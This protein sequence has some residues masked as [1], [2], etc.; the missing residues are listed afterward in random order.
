IFK[1]I[2]ILINKTFIDCK[3][4]DVVGRCIGATVIQTREV[5]NKAIGGV[6]FLDEAYTLAP[7][8]KESNDCARE[9]ADELLVWMNPNMDSTIQNP[10]FIFAGYEKSMIEDFMALNPGF[11]RRLKNVL[12]FKDFK[13]HELASITKVLLILM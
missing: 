11:P 5:A 10:I 7:K 4:S 6:V 8:T 13:A 12:V 3:R 9:A 2:G 1:D